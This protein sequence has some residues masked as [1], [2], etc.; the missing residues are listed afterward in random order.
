LQARFQHGVEVIA[1]PDQNV[2]PLSAVFA[3]QIDNRVSRRAAAREEI[4][5][6]PLF[7]VSVIDH[8]GHEMPYKLTWLRK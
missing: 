1:H 8:K 5:K 4:H 3:V 2:F 6:N 7:V